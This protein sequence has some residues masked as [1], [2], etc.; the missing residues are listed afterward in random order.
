MRTNIVGLAVTLVLG[1]GCRDRGRLIQHDERWG[2]IAALRA[3]GCLGK[4]SVWDA[5]DALSLAILRNA[6]ATSPDDLRAQLAAVPPPRQGT[7]SWIT[8][9]GNGEA[10]A[11][12]VGLQCDAFS[13]AGGLVTWFAHERAGWRRVA[14]FG[15]AELARPELLW[16]DPVA[17]RAIV[18]EIAMGTQGETVD[19]RA[20]TLRDGSF[21]Q[22]AAATRLRV[23]VFA[24]TTL[25]DGVRFRHKTLLDEF[26]PS[27]GV[28][29][30][31]EE[32]WTF[33]GP[34]PA[35]A[36]V[37]LTPWLDALETQCADETRPPAQAIG[38]GATL[39]SAT[40]GH[41]GKVEIALAGIQFPEAYGCPGVKVLS[42]VLVM[43][44]RGGLW[45]VVERRVTDLAGAYD[46][47]RVD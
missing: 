9:R 40:Q 14:T 18:A 31:Y 6:P 41:D 32:S 3:D 28:E 33:T 30:E 24:A 37:P 27:S 42:I 23:G 22:V 26:S 21:E 36:R 7:I 45:I 11:T 47:C 34:L 2:L 25:V 29:K 38:C 1:S 16:M 19:V 4:P 12:A 20:L 43:E 44:N 39:V 17:Q 5:Y 10:V 13:N 15:I 35:V 46:S 8:V